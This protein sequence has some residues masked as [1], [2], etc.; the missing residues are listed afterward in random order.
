MSLDLVPPKMEELE[1]PE[2][3]TSDEP[4][5]P[6]DLGIQVPMQADTPQL[7]QPSDFVQQLDFASLNPQPDIDRPKLLTIPGHIN[8]GKVGEGIG[9]IFDMKDLDRQPVPIFQPAPA[10]PQSLINEGLHGTVQVEFVVLVDGT[11]SQLYTRDSTDHRFDDAAVRGVGRWKFKP[12]M[13]NG[14]K[15]NTRM[16]VPI[17][18]KAKGGDE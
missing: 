11:V 15:V 3:V 1:E 8:R 16:M 18:F 10:A 17:V 4:T 13:K 2:T 5:P 7:P 6:D 9:K 14:R 12:G